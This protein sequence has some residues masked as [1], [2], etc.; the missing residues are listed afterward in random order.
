MLANMPITATIPVV[1]LDRAK[2]FYGQT[3]GLK[4]VKQDEFGATF[5][6]GHGCQLYIYLRAASKADHTLASWTVDDIYAEV[7]DLK[8]KGVTFEE[9]S[10]GP[11]KTDQSIASMGPMRAAWFRDS[12]G[13]ILG[14]TG[15]VK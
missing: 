6:A 3:L 9:Y 7:A 11:I 15:M 8:S 5:E 10:E 14:L 13:N 4:P 2:N 12:E 1:D